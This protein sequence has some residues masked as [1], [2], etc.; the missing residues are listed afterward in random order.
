[1]PQPVDMQT[2]AGR[3]TA[4]ERIQQIADRA[5]LAAQQRLANDEERARVTNET[6]THQL[7]PK[8]EEVDTETKRRNPFA[9]RRHKKDTASEEEQARDDEAHKFYSA[10]EQE[11]M[12]DDPDNHQFDVTI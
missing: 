7:E 3:I 9:G 12:A 2:E 1:M 4:A 10:D 6:V 11:H 8:G 5:S